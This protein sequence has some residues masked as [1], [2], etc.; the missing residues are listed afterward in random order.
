MTKFLRR[1]VAAVGVLVVLFLVLAL[2][3]HVKVVD[4]RLTGTNPTGA[5]AAETCFGKKSAEACIDA[6]GN[7]IPTTG[8]SQDLGSSAHPWNNVYSVTATNTGSQ[9][10]GTAGTMNAAG[11]G[12]TAGSLNTVNGVQV[13]T[14]VAITGIVVSTTIPVNSSYE[15]LL[16]T[17]STVILTSVPNISTTTVI[18]GSTLLP[19][20]T[21]LVLSSTAAG[22]VTFQDAGTLT[23]SQLQLGAAT[24]TVTQYKT[25]TLIWDATDGFWREISYGNN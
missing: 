8:S 9:T 10:N 3:G 23:G 21:Y 18:N 19:S 25:L 5:S 24:R 17:G 13:F 12:G 4:A 20:G 22:G 16:S 14:K 2:S 1:F 11:T 6:S 15:S 7:V